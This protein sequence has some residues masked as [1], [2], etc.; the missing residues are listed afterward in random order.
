MD[1]FNT[2]IGSILQDHLSD[3]AEQIRKR[4]W[5]DGLPFVI[6]DSAADHDY[7]VMKPSEVIGHLDYLYSA[8][9]HGENTDQQAVVDEFIEDQKKFLHFMRAGI[10]NLKY[11]IPRAEAR[12]DESL[13]EIY[14]SNLKKKQDLIKGFS[15]WL[16]TYEDGA[17]A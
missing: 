5:N 8:L 12:K 2:Q 6:K 14:K 15:K 11:L 3:H 4:Q 1:S 17:K 13:T 9:T 10:T 7:P 16:K